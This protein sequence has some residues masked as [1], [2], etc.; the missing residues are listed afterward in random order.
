MPDL[1]KGLEK[2]IED[3]INSAV[4][5]LLR[6]SSLCRQVSHHMVEFDYNSINEADRKMSYFVFS[7]CHSFEDEENFILVPEQILLQKIWKHAYQLKKPTD[8]QATLQKFEQSFAAGQ[9]ELMEED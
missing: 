1:Q 5:E 3:D 9:D 8:A 7:L 4:T 6:I 2:D